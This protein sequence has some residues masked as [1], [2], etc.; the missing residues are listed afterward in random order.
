MFMSVTKYMKKGYL[1]RYTKLA[2][3]KS[4]TTRNCESN[5]K[6]NNIC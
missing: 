2:K 3:T 5:S 4:V 6:T 1:K